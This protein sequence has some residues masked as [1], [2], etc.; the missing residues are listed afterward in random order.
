VTAGQLYR[1]ESVTH[2][3]QKQS[4]RPEI[5]NARGEMRAAWGPAGPKIN[6]AT[7]DAG[8]VEFDLI[9]VSDT[10]VQASATGHDTTAHYAGLAALAPAPALVS[11][12]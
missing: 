7:L 6:G 3:G 1:P 9:E 8:R 5:S 11:S 10:L 4:G 2:V 12:L